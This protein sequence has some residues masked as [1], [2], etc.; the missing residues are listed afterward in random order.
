MTVSWQHSMRHS[1]AHPAAALG[2][3]LLCAACPASDDSGTGDPCTQARCDSICRGGGLPGGTCIGSTCSC[4][5]GGGDAD[6]DA[7]ADGGIDA[8]DGCDERARWIYVVSAENQLIRFYPDELRLEPIGTLDCR[9]SGTGATPFSMSVDRSATAWVLYGP[10]VFGGNAGE[11]FRVSTADARC[12]S[13]TFERNQEGLEV[14]GMGFSSD[15]AGGDRETLFIGG[16]PQLSIGTGTATLATIDMASLR[17]GTIGALPGWPELTGTGAGE[18]WGFFPDTDP[19]TVSRID[20]GSGTVSDTYDLPIDTTS[21]EAWAFAFWGGDFWI[22]LKT[23]AD[24]STN[25]WKLETDDRS[26][27]NVY[28][29]TGWRIVGAGVSTCA[30]IILI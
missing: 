27:A 20:K 15:E 30:P 9:P 23:L 19:P 12:E 24:P 22:F 8:G 25:V 18:L 7:D 21:T 1:L 13:T 26:V 17:V 29:D 6:A 11:L 14:F 10:G 2:A 28:P 16:G 5:G 4:L 3:L